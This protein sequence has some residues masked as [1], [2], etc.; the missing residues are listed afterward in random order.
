MV[1]NKICEIVVPEN[2]KTQG[3]RGGGGILACLSLEYYLH[4]SQRVYMLGKF[5]HLISQISLMS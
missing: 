1:F 2:L 4:T 3:G 5:I